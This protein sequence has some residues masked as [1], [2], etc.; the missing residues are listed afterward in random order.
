MCWESQKAELEQR[1]EDGEEKA[2]KLE[3]YDAVEAMLYF[4][5]SKVLCMCI[6]FCHGRCDFRFKSTQ[7]W[8]L[9]LEACKM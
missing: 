7:S 8:G 5:L 1:A 9:E 6:V 4:Y 2:E 3:K